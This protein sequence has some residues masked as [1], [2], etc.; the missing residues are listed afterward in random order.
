MT[1]GTKL[2]YYPGCTLKT[3][4]RNLERAAL[5]ALDA[6]GVEYAE[7]PRWNCCG[8]VFSLADRISVLV[9]G[10]I[11]ATGGK[12]DIRANPEVQVAYLGED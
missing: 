2:S 10:Q 1:T 11:I 7:L 3:K 5:G 12:E 6:L 9:Y 8:A 4:A